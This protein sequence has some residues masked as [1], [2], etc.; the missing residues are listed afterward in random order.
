MAKLHCAQTVHTGPV[1]SH[2]LVHCAP[3][4]SGRRIKRGTCSRVDGNRSRG[5]GGVTRTQQRTRKPSNAQ[6]AGPQGATRGGRGWRRAG[7]HG[8]H[9]ETEAGPLPP[10]CLAV[11]DGHRHLVPRWWRASREAAGTD[12]ARGVLTPP[13]A[14][15][16]C[17]LSPDSPLL[18]LADFSSSFRPW[19]TCP[20]L[21][22]VLPVPCASKLKPTIWSPLPKRPVLFLCGVSQLVMTRARVRIS[23]KSP[24]PR[25]LSAPSVTATVAAGTAS[26]S[27]ITLSTLGDAQ[28]PAGI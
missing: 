24:F 3:G 18:P 21:S 13:Q 19:H 15:F 4:R 6:P 17:S 2:G 11:C 25:S 8:C 20:I 5:N 22:E 1:R 16:T 26:A 28:N 23:A 9:G 10:R 27:F 12:P 7:H 14:S